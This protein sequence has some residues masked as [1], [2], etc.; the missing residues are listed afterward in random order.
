VLFRSAAGAGGWYWL[1]GGHRGEGTELITAAASMP[2]EVTDDVRA[3]AYAFTAYFLTAGQGDQFKAQDWIHQAYELSQRVQH[4]H[5]ALG[6][7]AL[8]ERM[9]REPAD[10]LPAFDPLLV[11]DDPW[12][13]A[14]ARLTRGRMRIMLGRDEREADADIETALAEFRV[15]GERW[16]ISSGLSALADRLAIRGEFDRACLLY[17]QAAESVT[18]VG[19]IEDVLRIRANQAQAHWVAGDPASSA[20][21]M[22]EAERQADRII[23]P[24]AL[25]E[26]AM[27]KAELARWQGDPA[28]ARRQLAYAQSVF[29]DSEEHMQG[30]TDD[31]LGYLADDLGEAREH[32]AAALR[33]AM[34]TVHAPL[35]AR[36]LVGIADFALRSEQFEQAARLL[37]AS[38]SVRGLP[39]RSQP[40]VARIEQTARRRL[41][42]TRFTEATREGAGASWRELAEVTLA[43]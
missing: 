41:G 1:L 26:L 15:L 35:I 30:V 28:E 18:Q 11:D 25:A 9:V 33:V 19:A 43:W 20:A 13:R 5:P 39:D 37:G 24:D 8:L 34:N 2:G 23:W 12:T 6:F 38:T 40:D 31:L 22:A 17:D 42:D 3:T 21:A 27:A 10:F 7:V 32:R 16:G 36:V 29:E 14:Q 4:W